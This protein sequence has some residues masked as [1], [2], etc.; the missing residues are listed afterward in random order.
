LIIV[1]AGAV[2]IS[3]WYWISLSE[4]NKQLIEHVRIAEEAA[5]RAKLA[6][7]L[8][9]EKEFEAIAN[10]C[11]TS[12]EELRA[13]PR[14]P[15]RLQNFLSCGARY[16]FALIRKSKPEEAKTFL[17]RVRE[18]ELT[19]GSKQ[20][21]PITAFHLLLISQAMAI[22]ECASA[23]S[24]STARSECIHPLAESVTELATFRPPPSQEWRWREDTYPNMIPLHEFEEGIWDLDHAVPL[25][26]PWTKGACN[27]DAKLMIIAQDWSSENYLL[28]PRNR[29]RWR[30]ML[31]THFGQDPHLQTNRN[32]RKLLRC[33]RIKWRETYATDVSVFVK[34][35][36]MTG[37]VPN[38]V[39]RH[40]AVQYTLR[41]MRIVQPRMVLCLGTKT[42]N[43][44]RYALGKTPLN[45]SDASKAEPHTVDDETEVRTEI[46]DVPHTGGSGFAAC[47]GMPKILPI[48]EAIAERFH[49]LA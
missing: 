32:I 31:R 3:C 19:F 1:M 20:D 25:V 45:M 33:F 38:S 15:G 10:E 35:G 24:K 6:N 46:Y 36:N 18:V 8:A 7:Q 48:W 39:M 30:D 26:V 9:Q 41:Q 37:D 40:C 5:S 16:A 12:E 42:F 22:A 11:T 44:V 47:G 4:S 34:P 49:T 2:G 43:S 14:A 21:D 27:V 28:N 29:T 23:A 17:N 13:D